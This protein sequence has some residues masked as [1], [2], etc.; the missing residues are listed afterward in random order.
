MAI[1]RFISSSIAVSGRRKQDQVQRS[2]GCISSEGFT[3]SL[4]PPKATGLTAEDSGTGGDF[5]CA[6]YPFALLLRYSTTTSTR[7]LAT[8][9]RASHTT[10]IGVIGPDAFP[11]MA[12]SLL[13]LLP[14][15]EVKKI[16]FPE[17]TSLGRTQE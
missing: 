5:F 7:S 3:Q 14:A 10:S 2:S 9:L 17:S 4:P 6:L 16:Q 8:G 1:K 13:D 12:L 15:F 11:L